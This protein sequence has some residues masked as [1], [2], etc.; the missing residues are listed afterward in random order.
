VWGVGGKMQTPLC[1]RHYLTIKNADTTPTPASVPDGTNT[2]ADQD[3]ETRENRA[4]NIADYKLVN[5]VEKE[6]CYRCGEL[7]YCT[8]VEKLTNENRVERLN[9]RPWFLCRKC[10]KELLDA[11]RREIEEIK[12]L[13]DNRESAG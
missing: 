10:A 8:H 4:V 12:A 1:D 11:A 3:H 7:A 5:G 2:L 9:R 13:K 6:P